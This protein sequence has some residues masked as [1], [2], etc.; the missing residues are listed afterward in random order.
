MSA[1]IRFVGHCN[2]GTVDMIVIGV[3]THKRFHALAA[4]DGGTGRIRGQREIDADQDGHLTG[5]R[6]AA[7]LDVER[8]WAI[9]DCRGVSSRL[10]QA[11]LAAGERVLRV[12]PHRMGAS[13]RAEREAGKSDQ[14]DAM[15][16]A[17]AVLKDG[18]DAFPAAYL[19]EA[20]E[21]IRLLS[22]HRTNLVASRTTLQNRLRWHLVILCPELERSIKRGGLSQTSVLDRLDRR[23]RRLSGPRARIAREQIATIRQHTRRINELHTQLTGLI[24]IHHPELLREPGCG[25]IC[26][27][28]IIGHT[29]GAQ[30]FPTDG[31]FARHAGAAPIPCSSGQRQRVYRL[32]R[33]G[34]RQLNHALHIIAVT[35]ARTDPATAAYIQRKL[36]EGK[37]TKGALRS[38]KRHLARHIHRLLT[39]PPTIQTADTPPLMPCLK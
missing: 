32:N 29:A 9:E 35:R 4:V 2:E 10:E 20:A 22:D 8:V 16:I 24:K 36:A 13:R 25:T 30:R 28:L 19:D 34:D 23:L 39:T 38:L 14:I 33:G 17:R 3:D 6:W 7:G 18:I 27:A 21:Q 26:A 15:A 37:T 1:E 5:V 11:L 12:A 31:H